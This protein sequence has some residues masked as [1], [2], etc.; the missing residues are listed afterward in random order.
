MGIYPSGLPLIC[1]GGN[2]GQQ[3]SLS[4]AHRLFGV[5]AEPLRVSAIT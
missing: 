5:G 4:I 2:R 1:Y 3:K